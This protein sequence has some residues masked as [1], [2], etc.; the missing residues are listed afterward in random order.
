MNDIN[1]Q[2]NE[3]IICQED[4]VAKGKTVGVCINSIVLTN[5]NFYCLNKNIVGSIKSIDKFPLREIQMIG[6]EPHV[7]VGT[8]MNGQSTLEIHTHG[9][10]EIYQFNSLGNSKA[11]KWVNLIYQQ[12]VGHDSNEKTILGSI[13]KIAKDVTSTG[14][15]MIGETVGTLVN[16][17]K[18]GISNEGKPTIINTKCKSCHAPISGQKGQIIKCKY[19][20]TKQTL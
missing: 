10:T 7:R 6:G 17:F 4:G 1:L 16:S 2:S 12:I 14:A 11:V 20:D 3:R 8:S 19:C 15:G 9:S 18:E 13:S 5:L